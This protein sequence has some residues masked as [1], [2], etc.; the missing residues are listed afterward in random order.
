MLKNISTASADVCLH[1]R[2]PYTNRYR[3]STGRSF[4]LI[5]GNKKYPLHYDFQFMTHLKDKYTKSDPNQVC[6]GSWGQFAGEN[7]EYVQRVPV[8]PYY[9]YMRRFSK[10]R[11]KCVC[12]T[13]KSLRFCFQNYM[14]I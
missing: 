10:S 9:K 2:Q 14:P 12:D 11:S 5:D 8:R 6:D 13:R 7:R 1:I 4:D 3:E